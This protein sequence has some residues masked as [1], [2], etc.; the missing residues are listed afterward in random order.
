[1]KKFEDLIFRERLGGIQ[2]HFH[3]DNGYSISV[4]RFEGT[5]GY[6]NGLYEVCRIRDGRLDG[7]PIGNLTP[8][9]VT[10]IMI[11]IQR[12]DVRTIPDWDFDDEENIIDGDDDFDFDC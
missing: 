12:M 7:E 1:M 8:I 4:V 6:E 3:F 10:E 5:I 11:E 9:Q 2:S